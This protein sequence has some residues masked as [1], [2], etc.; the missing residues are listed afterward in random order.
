MI[1]AKGFAC[2]RC[3]VTI[4]SRL[5]KLKRRGIPNKEVAYRLWKELEATPGLKLDSAS[6][7]NGGLTI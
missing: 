5:L 3:Y 1:A 4:I 2:Q 6:F 7:R